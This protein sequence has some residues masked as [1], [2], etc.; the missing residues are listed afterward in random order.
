MQ[1]T[2]ESKPLGLA[3]MSSVAAVVGACCVLACVAALVVATVLLTTT[4]TNEPTRKA[5]Y[6]DEVY[7]GM[8]GTGMIGTGT[9]EERQ[10]KDNMTRAHAEL[11][12]ANMKMRWGWVLLIGGSTLP[13]WLI[14]SV[15]GFIGKQRA[16]AGKQDSGS[17]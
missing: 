8:V 7:R 16:G 9:V 1:K 13:I 12:M 3:I 5:A 14:V 10:F 6:H 11:N 4:D 15:L 17:A 2:E